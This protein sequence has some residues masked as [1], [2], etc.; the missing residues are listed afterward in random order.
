MKQT[1]FFCH[2][3]TLQIVYFLALT[4][5]KRY[6]LL[7]RLKWGK[8]VTCHIVFFFVF[9]WTFFD[10]SSFAIIEEI[11]SVDE[12]FGLLSQLVNNKFILQT[13]RL[14]NAFSPLCIRR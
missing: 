7:Q 13:F 8:K 3:D 6:T 2:L 11:I 4:E 12:P 5:G 9:K 14:T 1:F 10:L